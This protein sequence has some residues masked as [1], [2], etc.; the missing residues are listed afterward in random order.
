[1]SGKQQLC[2]KLKRGKK[3]IFVYRLKTNK[4]GQKETMNLNYT[5]SKT[6][7]CK[8]F[9]TSAIQSGNFM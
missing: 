6:I 3:K 5:S 4:N 2:C 8:L 9:V 7:K 1:M